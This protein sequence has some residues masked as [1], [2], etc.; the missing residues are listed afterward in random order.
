APAQRRGGKGVVLRNG[1]CA[2]QKTLPDRTVAPSR[3]PQDYHEISGLAAEPKAG[4]TTLSLA[5]PATGWQ[6]GD[7]LVLPDTRQLFDTNRGANY[8]AQE[9]NLKIQSISADGLTI[10]LTAPLQFNHLGARDAKGVLNYLPHVADLS[11]NVVIH[12]ANATGNRGQVL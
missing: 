9:E 10:T 5:A 4:A 1:S 7:N 3:P 2:P 6:V 12:S 8:V 11:R